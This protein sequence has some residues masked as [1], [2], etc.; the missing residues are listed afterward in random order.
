MVTMKRKAAIKPI[1]VSE[2]FFKNH[3]LERSSKKLLIPW[4]RIGQS[5][6]CPGSELNNPLKKGVYASI[7]NNPTDVKTIVH[8]QYEG[9]KANHDRIRN[10]RN[11]AAHL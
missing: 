1:L 10:L 8:R 6:L 9:V 7:P 5:R 4:K 2:I 11:Q 3:M